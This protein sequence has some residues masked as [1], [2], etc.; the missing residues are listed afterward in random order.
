MKITNTTGYMPTIKVSTA[1]PAEPRKS[2][3]QS[4]PKTTVTAN[5]YIELNNK[6]AAT[7]D[8]DLA[9]VNEIRDQLK[10]GDLKLDIEKLSEAIIAMHR[11]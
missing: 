8:I 3:P 6:I 4:A 11:K 2:E 10:N 7:S 9:K 1:V 5:N